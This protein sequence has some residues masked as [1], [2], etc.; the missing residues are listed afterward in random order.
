M[1]KLQNKKM[2]AI[3]SFFIIVLSVVLFS[4][5]KVS[6][7]ESMMEGKYEPTWE[8]LSQ[9]GE[10]PEWFQDAKFG[11]WAH[12]GPQCQPEQGDWYARGMYDEGRHQYN[13][14]VQNYGHPSEFGLIST[15]K[16]IS[17]APLM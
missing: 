16:R 3:K 5:C 10:A 14:H 9:Y 6:P 7:H 4:S 12:W 8:S 13:W 1:L 2:K 17:F 15:P 11:I